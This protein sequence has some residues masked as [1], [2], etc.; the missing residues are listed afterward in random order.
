MRL[1]SASLGALRVTGW[2]MRSFASLRMTLASL[3]AL[4]LGLIPN[5]GYNS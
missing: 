4:G 5:S 2:W 1:R 3:V